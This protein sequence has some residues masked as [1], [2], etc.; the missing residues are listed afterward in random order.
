LEWE[1]SSPPG[2]P[3]SK[4]VVELL[5]DV[6]VG[7]LPLRDKLEL[8]VTTEPK[9]GVLAVIDDMNVVLVADIVERGE[10]S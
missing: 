10:I 2:S 5:S 3:G 9:M 4:P 7:E 8:V 1:S 6:V